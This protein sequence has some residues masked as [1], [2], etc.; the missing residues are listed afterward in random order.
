MQVPEVIIRF[1]SHAEKE[2]VLKLATLLDGIIVGANLFEATPGATASLLWKM[3]AKNTKIFLDP[4]TYAF[5]SYIDRKTRELCT[6]LS[7][8]KST[9]KRKNKNGEK[10]T[11]IDFKRSYKRLAE[12]LGNPLDK[13]I[14]T[15][16]AISK[17]SFSDPSVIQEFCETVA[18]YQINRIKREFEKDPDLKELAEDA[19]TPTAVFAPYFYIEP[20]HRD[21]WLTLGLELMKATAS[22]EVESP[23]HGVLCADVSQLKDPTFVTHIIE[24]IPKTGVTGI[25]LWFSRLFE[26]TASTEVLKAYRDLVSGLSAK[27]SEIYSMHGGFYSLALSKFGMRGVSH[28]I[29]YGEQKDVIPIIGQSIPTVRY[30]LPPV[31]RRL[32]VPQIQRAFQGIGVESAD[33]FH[34]KVCN[35]AICLGVIENSLDEFRQFGDMRYSRPDAQRMSQTPAAAKRCRYHFLL[36]RLRERDELRNKPIKEIFERLGEASVA[37]GTQPSLEKLVDHLNRWSSLISNEE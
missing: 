27:I 14:E 31:M 26:E 17:E 34:N 28:G 5:G 29:G 3:K 11:Y 10:E 2:Y 19:P 16:T 21:D 37:W 25:W 30:Y 9:Q 18:Q 20:T 32:G 4:M 22:L 6:N 15:G 7:W 23:V 35:C 8:I 12:E 24:E 13:A 36:S 1:G 33:D